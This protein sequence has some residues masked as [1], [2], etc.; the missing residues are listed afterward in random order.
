MMPDSKPA[1]I[2]WAEVQ[3]VVAA[4]SEAFSETYLCRQE[5]SGLNGIAYS[6]C[7]REGSGLNGTAYVAKKEVA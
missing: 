4:T 7:R 1:S 2:E 6:L 3:E 5:G